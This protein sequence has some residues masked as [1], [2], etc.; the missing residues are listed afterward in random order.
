MCDTLYNF[1]ISYYY[2]G[3][4]SN[5]ND[6]DNCFFIYKKTNFFVMTIIKVTMTTRDKSQTIFYQNEREII[7]NKRNLM[8]KQT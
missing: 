7:F 4:N 3:D 8:I 2:Y 1:E 6:D 5:N